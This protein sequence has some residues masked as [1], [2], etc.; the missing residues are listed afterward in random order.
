MLLKNLGAENVQILGMS[1][2]ESHTTNHNG[3][4]KR[5]G[6]ISDFLAEQHPGMD[7]H[8]KHK[9]IILIGP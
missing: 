1:S 6:K 4:Y 5:S 7:R 8:T 3:K 9:E 2:E